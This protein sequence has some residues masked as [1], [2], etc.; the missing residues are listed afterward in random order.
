MVPTLSWIIVALSLHITT[1]NGRPSSTRLPEPDPSYAVP[2]ELGGNTY[3]NKGLVAFGLIPSNFTD[4]TGNTMGGFGSAIALKRGLFARQSDGTFT[5]TIV[6]QP[7]RGFNVDGTIDYQGRQHQIDFVLL[8]FYG[9]NNLTFDAAL[10][11]LK[12]SYRNTLLYTERNDAATTGLDAL[13]IRP[14]TSADPPLPEAPS[15]D[16]L[17]L[18][19]EGLVLNADGTFW[20]SDEY[21]PY[22]YLFSEQAELIKAIQPPQ[23][24]LPLV[25]GELNFTSD[26]DPDTGRAGNQGFEGLTVSADGHTLYALLQSATIQDGGSDKTTSRFTRL[27]AFNVSSSAAQPPLVGEWVVPLPQSKKGKTYAS[28][29]LH[30]VSDNVFLVLSRDSDGHGGDDNN[31]AYKQADLIDITDATDIHNTE[32]DDPSKPISPDGEL[33]ST[34]NP[35]TYVSFVSFIDDTQLAR[36]GLHNGK[37]AD[38][39]LI[40]AKWESLALAPVGD[41]DFPDDYFLFTVSDNDFITTQGISLGQPYNAGLDNDNQ[42]L[43]FRV[44]LPGAS[45]P[46]VSRSNRRPGLGKVP[47]RQEI[48]Q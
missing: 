46:G 25:K 37:P 19:A 40:D 7:D 4:S 24:I 2:V 43:V 15:N 9:T 8:P 31:S 30:F 41:P 3:I 39:T 28:S 12:L 5:G 26:S 42:F 14:S 32:F 29:E 45:V 13:A 21:G 35:A 27:V 38:Q 10:T 22:I 36:F 47:W 44:T 48:I 20:T 11:T 34:I 18:D 1:S 23:A 16:H 6:A 33:D 17:S